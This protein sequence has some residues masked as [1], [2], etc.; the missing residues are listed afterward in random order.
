MIKK[1]IFDFDVNYVSSFKGVMLSKLYYAPLV[2][3]FLYNLNFRARVNFYFNLLIV[4][5]HS[6]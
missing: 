3:V 6:I 1:K 2:P 4:L 5:D